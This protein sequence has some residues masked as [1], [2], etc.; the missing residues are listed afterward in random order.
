[1]FVE[2]ARTRRDNKHVVKYGTRY[3]VMCE[4]FPR[5][6]FVQ[7]EKVVHGRVWDPSVELVMIVRGEV[8]EHEVKTS[9]T[10]EI[11]DE[12][13]IIEVEQCPIYDTTKERDPSA[14]ITMLKYNEVDEDWAFQID[15][16]SE[17]I[18]VKSGGRR[19]CDTI[20]DGKDVESDGEWVLETAG[21]KG[22]LKPN[23][24][25]ELEWKIVVRTPGLKNKENQPSKDLVDNY[26]TKEF[27]EDENFMSTLKELNE[28][29]DLERRQAKRRESEEE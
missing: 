27:Y 15:I 20:G 22:M 29:Q 25:G 8:G 28:A 4:S 19:A 14:D 5:D 24:F 2:E 26:G 18:E 23:D 17:V 11:V 1:M 13:K 7:G 16:E 6:E 10:K 21:E 12:W 9:I 3:Q